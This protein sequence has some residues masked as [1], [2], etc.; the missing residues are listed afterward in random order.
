MDQP[1]HNLRSEMQARAVGLLL[2]KHRLLVNWG[3]G[4]GKSRVAVESVDRLYSAGC[5]R[6]LL[7][8]AETAH[9][10]NWLNE[11]T[12][13]KG[14]ERGKCLFDA[15]TVECYASLKKYEETE[16]D[17]IVADEGHHMR[18]DNRTKSLATMKSNYVLVLSATLSD[19][20]DGDELIRT[21]IGTFGQFESVH[22]GLQDAIDHQILS[23]PQIYVHL[24]PLEKIRERQQVVVEWGV[25]WYRKERECEYADFESLH[26]SLK[27]RSVKMTVNCSAK[28]GYDLLTKW[29]EGKKKECSDLLDEIARTA[30]DEKRKRL[31]KQLQYLQNEVKQYGMRRKMLLGRSKTGFA[32]WLIKKYLSDKKFI[33][34]CTDIPQGEALGGENIIHSQRKGNLNVIRAFNEGEINSLFAVGM[35]KEGQNLAG[36]EA[37]LIVQLGGKERDFIQ[38]FGRAMRSSSPVQ[39]ILVF[40][41]TRD[42]IYYKNAIGPQDKDAGLFG[43]RGINPKY[44]HL[45]RY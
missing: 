21:L 24:L 1:N 26:E 12:G 30:G 36:I 14:P 34:F 28:E 29:Y 45:L 9:K 15:L 6:I 31:L 43:R 42:V 19:K 17:L 39:H 18:S 4:V 7:L 25:P 8:V 16:W 23:E 38:E 13:C 37:G 44:I 2:E 11:F 22:F 3:T 33:C 10:G 32:K 27:E 5:R 41:H 35:I 40:N 20:R